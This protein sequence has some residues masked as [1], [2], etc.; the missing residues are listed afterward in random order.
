MNRQNFIHDSKEIHGDRYDYSEVKYV[1]QI[2]KVTLICKKHGEFFQYP[3]YHLPR[4]TAQIKQQIC[5]LKLNLNLPFI[6]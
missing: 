1:N 5:E 2:T 6:V 3:K 4:V